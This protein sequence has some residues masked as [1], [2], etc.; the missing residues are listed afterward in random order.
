MPPPRAWRFIFGNAAGKDGLT[1]GEA[2]LTGRALARALGSC[3]RVG[4]EWGDTCC[5]TSRVVG[6]RSMREGR[7]GSRVDDVSCDV[8]RDGKRR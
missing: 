1:W 5:L 6:G 3:Q 8:G 4:R 7:G 2:T